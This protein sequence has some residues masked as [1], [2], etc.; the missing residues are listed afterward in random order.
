M[1]FEKL[2]NLF[3]NK[4]YNIDETIH[5][6]INSTQA[7]QISTPHRP[8]EALDN[9]AAIV[10]R[11]EWSHHAV[12]K[13]QPLCSNCQAERVEPSRSFKGA[14]FVQQLSSGAR[15]VITQFQRCSLCAAFVV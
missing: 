2:T 12:S 10:K 6:N 15:M 4:K 7:E 11:S 3:I 5:A 9:C 13:A 1:I 14:A 8:S